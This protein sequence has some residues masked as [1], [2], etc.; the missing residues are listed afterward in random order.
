MKEKLKVRQIRL[1][2][3][4]VVAMIIVYTYAAYPFLKEELKYL[5]LKKET[6]K[7]GLEV[8]NSKKKFMVWLNKVSRAL[9]AKPINCSDKTILRALGRIEHGVY[10]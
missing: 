6:K 9:N 8:F 10:A 5:N 4:I 3:S 1:H 2:P 7:K